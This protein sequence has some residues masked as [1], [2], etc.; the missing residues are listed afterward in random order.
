MLK[1][2]LREKK[3]ENK[4]FFSQLSERDT[5]FMIEQS[6]QEEQTESRDSMICR[7]AS[8]D[9]TTSATQL[10]YPQV[11]VHTLEENIVSKVRSEVDN[12]MTSVETKVQDAVLTEMES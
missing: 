7:S 9:N 1:W 2:F 6:N 3:T 5:D 10:N 11:D 4:T 8:S 12:V